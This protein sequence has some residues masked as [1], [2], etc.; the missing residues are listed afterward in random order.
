MSEA[1]TAGNQ[2][3]LV[4]TNGKGKELADLLRRELGIP[5]GVREFSVRFALGEVIMVNCT[6]FAKAAKE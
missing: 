5:G 4:P 2:P 3:F 1:A 6:Y